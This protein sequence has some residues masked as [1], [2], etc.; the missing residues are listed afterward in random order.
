[1]ADHCWCGRELVVKGDSRWEIGTRWY[2]CPEHGTNIVLDAADE[3][4]E[5]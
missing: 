3:E 4:G 5:E 1:M 2:E